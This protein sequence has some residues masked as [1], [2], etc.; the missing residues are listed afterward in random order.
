MREWIVSFDSEVDAR[1][2]YRRVQ[3]SSARYI[4][5]DGRCVRIQCPRD[6]LYHY[7]SPIDGPHWISSA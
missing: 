2:F 4:M 3:G 5:L 6:L 1:R 7:L